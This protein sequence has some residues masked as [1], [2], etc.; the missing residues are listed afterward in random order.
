MHELVVPLALAGVEV[1]CEQRLAEQVVAGA[2]DAGVVPSRLL[3]GQIHR[4]ELL[5]DGDL[6]PHARVAGVLVRAL[7]PAFRTEL[8]AHRHGVED[9]QP[10]ARARV[11]PSHVTLGRA[12]RRRIRTRWVRGTDDDDVLRDD[13]RRV[14]ADLSVQRVEVLIDVLLQIDNAA[15]TEALDAIAGARVERDHLV[16][17]RHVDDALVVAA[18]PI[19]EPAARQL[20]RR[21]LAAL[22]FVEP[23]DPEQLA[24][25]GVERDDGAARARRRVNDTVDHERRRLKIEL[26][27]RPQAV[28]LEPP[29]DLETTEIAGVDLVERRVARVAEIAAV[30]RPFATGSAALR[31]CQRRH[32]RQTDRDTR[33]QVVE[34]HPPPLLLCRQYRPSPRPTACAGLRASCSLEGLC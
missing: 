10:L 28:G 4:L 18:L 23:M 9:P 24:V 15:V 11:E 25:A 14:Q 34:L 30:G 26:A 27:V 16:A 17:R 22:A 32:Q 20:P 8:A 7:Q 2:V 1:D 13:R 3:D 31:Q 21:N 33:P 19:R 29:R 12:R 5:V 6:R